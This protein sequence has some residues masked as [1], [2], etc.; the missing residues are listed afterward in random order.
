MDKCGKCGMEASLAVECC[1]R[2]SFY[3]SRCF[4]G[5]H[6][7]FFSITRI[8]WE[9]VDFNPRDEEAGKIYVDYGL[10]LAVIAPI[11]HTASSDN[12][13]TSIRDSWS[14]NRP[15]DTSAL[16]KKGGKRK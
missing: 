6:A 2:V 16:R 12:I 5:K 9:I 13:R 3:C 14:T 8:K 1:N 10:T 7:R 11:G 15:A 4:L